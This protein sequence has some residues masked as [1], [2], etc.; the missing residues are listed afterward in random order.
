[1][2]K[3]SNSLP[4]IEDITLAELSSNPSFGGDTSDGARR[5]KAIILA[6][7]DE[8][9]KEVIFASPEVIALDLILPCLIKTFL[10]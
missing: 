5:G 2:E 6:K 10:L 1:M 3:R 9:V 8:D 4:K 7:K